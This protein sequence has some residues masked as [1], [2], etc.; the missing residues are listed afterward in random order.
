MELRI[1][2]AALPTEIVGKGSKAECRVTDLSSVQE[3]GFRVY[4]LGL[5]V[6]SV[7]CRV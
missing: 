2:V 6:T 7:G 4:D 3:V 5:R 1:E